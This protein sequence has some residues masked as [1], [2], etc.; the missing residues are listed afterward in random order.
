MPYIYYF[1]YC[2]WPARVV[3]DEDGKTVIQSEV[4]DPKNCKLVADQTMN[5]TYGLLHIDRQH[6]LKEDEYVISEAEFNAYSKADCRTSLRS[7]ARCC[8]QII[9]DDNNIGR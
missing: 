2:G 9:P 3:F 5:F 1:D 7:G 8:L 4:W 6:G